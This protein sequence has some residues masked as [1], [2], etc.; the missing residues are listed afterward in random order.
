M[1]E[2]DKSVDALEVASAIIISIAGL[3][4]SW[5]SYEAGLWDGDQAAHYTRA[6]L[7]RV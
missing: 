6:N 7:L 5:A 3:G 2:D 4:A 1:A